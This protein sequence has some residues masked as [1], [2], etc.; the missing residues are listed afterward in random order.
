ML[1]FI[2]KIYSS[3]NFE[4][5]WVL[6]F[7]IFH[8]GIY[9]RKLA[10]NTNLRFYDRFYFCFS[11]QKCGISRNL[12][13]PSF[14]HFCWISNK[15]KQNIRDFKSDKQL[16][17]LLYHQLFLI[18]NKANLFK[19]L[20]YFIIDKKTFPNYTISQIYVF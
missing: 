3:N 1:N 13:L 15:A 16:L 6:K 12:T 20:F 4:W 19:K 5:K 11:V 9:A 10:G 7:Q 14:S 8:W 17:L 2:T 18:S